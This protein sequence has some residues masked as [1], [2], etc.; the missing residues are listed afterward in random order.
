MKSPD[1]TNQKFGRLTVLRRDSKEN[2]KDSAAYW[3]CKCDCGKEVVVRSGSLRSGG[4]KSCGCLRR[5]RV[6]EKNTKNLVGQRFGSLV[7]LE[8]DKTKIGEASHSYWICKCDCGNIKSIQ[9]PHLIQQTTTSCGCGIGNRKKSI[10]EALIEESLIELKIPYQREFSFVDLIGTTQPL[11][12]DFAIFENNDKQEIKC[13]IEF[14]GK[15]HYQSL[16]YFGGNKYL[17]LTKER[18]LKKKE[19]CN[20]NNFKLIEISYK[21]QN[22]INLT[23]I[24]EILKKINN[25]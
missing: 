21:E 1:L 25:V 3:I 19:Y 7:V 17:Q 22:K 23:Y 2:H 5:E 6:I 14:Q 16:D 18:D 12:F 24:K 13:L 15:Q 10:G 8:K 4:T 20:K 9:S 11:R